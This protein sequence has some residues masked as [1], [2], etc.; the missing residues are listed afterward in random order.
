[1]SQR[2]PLLFNPSRASFEELEK[3]FVGRWPQLEAFERDLLAD[4]AGP[5]TRHWLLIGPRGSGK[6]H[7]TELLSRRLRQNH[8]WGV[9]RLPEE[10]YQV[11][12]VAELLEQI[13]IR[14]EGLKAS[15]FA[16]E[17]DPRRVEELAIDRLRAWRQKHGKPC[18][19]VLENLGQFLDRK[20]TA[21]RDQSRLR[22]VLM[23]EP[24]FILLAT[25]TS[26]VEATV[27]HSAPFYDFFQIST[28]DELSREEVFGLVQA[29]AQWDQDENLLGRMEQVRLR[30]EAIFHFSGGNPRLVLALYGVLRHGVTEDLH[31]QLLEL[32]DEVTP[33]YQARL[34][35]VSPQMVRILTE[36]ALAE[37]PLTPSEIGRRTR[38]TTPQVTANI[39]KL[40]DERFVR[41]GGRPED[42]RS[43]Y[44]ELTDRLFRLWMQMREGE[45]IRQRLRFLTEFFQHWYDSNWDELGHDVVRISNAFWRELDNENRGRCQD[46]LRTLDYLSEAFPDEHDTLLVRQLDRASP[47]AVYDSRLIAKLE[48]MRGNL[49]QIEQRT[50][51]GYVLSGLYYNNHRLQ[52]ALAV[53]GEAIDQDAN[54]GHWVWIRYLDLL[55]ELNGS[56]FAYDEA[57]KAM[58]QNPARQGLHEM[59]SVLASSLG[60]TEAAIQH[61]ETYISYV[62]CPNCL[63]SALLLRIVFHLQAG[64]IQEADRTLQQ[65]E[66]EFCHYDP[67]VVHFLRL[68]VKMA[69]GR[70]VSKDQV[71]DTIGSIGRS[72]YLPSW[73]MQA[74][75][76]VL[77]RR[78][79]TTSKPFNPIKRNQDFG[80][81]GAHALLLRSVLKTLVRSRA[82]GKPLAAELEAWLSDTGSHAEVLAKAFRIHMPRLARVPSL[83]PHVLECYRRL[84]EGGVLTEDIPPYST[85]LTV[86][87]ALS[88]ER[89]LSALHPE[90][91]EAVALLLGRASDEAGDSKQQSAS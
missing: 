76:Y 82:R 46:L 26:Y 75:A 18:L 54:A 51:I 49:E 12:S 19:V 68:C 25:A 28:L 57:M 31:T 70:S 34:N 44:Y 27:E 20:L 23:Q 37:G 67:S 83:R 21:R 69:Q 30:L 2:A 86:Q 85:A 3:T 79:A 35:D 39:T 32:L 73:V 87:E 84:R 56:S 15:P 74:A 80:W 8:G 62:Q 36:M 89:A 55:S 60:R 5:S 59:L 1:M 61:L 64:E 66:I 13:I 41:P 71:L 38:L 42:Q 6:S 43:R 33:Y 11:A 52:D 91:R 58:E 50:A 14:L 72:K 88:A 63:G 17:R 10:H 4:G 48:E 81:A 7:F 16:Q 22:E 65:Q 24:P 40:G 77:V 53:V 29:R 47:S 90:M 45:P 9:A 78:D